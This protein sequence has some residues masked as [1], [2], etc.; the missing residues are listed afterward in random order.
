MRRA[1]TKKPSIHLWLYNHSLHGVSDQVSFFVKCFHQH[2]YRVTL[3]RRPHPLSLNVVIERF[4]YRDKDVLLD[5]CRSTRKRVA[6]IMTEHL[7]FEHGQ[8]FFHGE[9]LGSASD[10]MPPGTVMSRVT[11]LLECLPYIRCFF[12]LGDLPELR[13]ISVML[14]G[15]EVRAIPFPRLEDVPFAGSGR[16]EPNNDFVFTGG[17][18]NY[19]SEILNSLTAGCVSVVNPNSYLSRCRRNALNLTSK[20]ILNIPQ[21]EGWR[22]LSLM[23]IIAGL[24]VGRAT[25]SVGTRDTSRIASCCTQIDLP[26]KD[27]IGELG[28][29]AATWKALYVRDIDSYVQMAK[30]FR[31][32]HPFPHDVLEYWSITDRVYY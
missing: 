11:N 6:V 21:W 13:N 22:W 28:Q 10:Y 7:D 23:R 2:G 4:S 3:G 19:R 32:Q 9:P 5:F 30:T 25:V 16:A 20:L 31:E 26:R 14:P 27:W 12:V 15:V 18:T 29:C 8:V 24:Q 1:D 17:M